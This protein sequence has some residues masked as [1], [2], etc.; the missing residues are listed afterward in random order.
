MAVAVAAPYGVGWGDAGGW[1]SPRTSMKKSA[2]LLSL[3][4]RVTFFFPY[5]LVGQAALRLQCLLQS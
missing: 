2:V 1:Q 3:R 5:L 4:L